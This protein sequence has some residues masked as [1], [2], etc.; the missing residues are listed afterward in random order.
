[1]YLS[2]PTKVSRS[3][4]LFNS[5]NNGG[6]ILN[7]GQ[8]TVVNSTL[9]YNSAKT[10][11]GGIYNFGNTFVYNA[12]LIGNSADS[13]NNNISE[14]GGGVYADSSSG[15]RFVVINT[16]MASNYVH[17]QPIFNDCA[18]TLEVYGFNLFGNLSNCAFSGNGTAARGLVTPG[19]IGGLVD[20]GGPT[21]THALLQFSEAID[22]TMAQGCIDETGALLATDQR[23]AP[24]VAYARCDVGAFEFGSIVPVVDLIFRNGLE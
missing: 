19:T 8:L 13:D 11:G 6:G 12:T 15:H 17:G 14:I 23:G 7:L 4:L 20:N 3:T 18:G 22:G 5:A 1:M 9:S 16:L 10:Y 21:Q 2:G 24:R